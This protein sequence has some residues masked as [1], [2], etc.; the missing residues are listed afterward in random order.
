MR[1]FCG[2]TIDRNAVAAALVNERGGVIATSSVS[3][4]PVGY[5]ELCRMWVRHTDPATVAVADDG[6]LRTLNSLCSASG[7]L[8]ASVSAGT[9]TDPLDR[10]VDIAQQLAYGEITAQAVPDADDEVR[11]LASALHVLAAAGHAARGAVVELLRQCHPAALSAWDDPTEPAALEL[12]CAIPDPADAVRTD[13]TQLA[14]VLRERADPRRISEL[15]PALAR[16]AADYDRKQ[17]A[18][19]SAAVV[20]AAEAALTNERACDALT[21][22]L[23]QRLAETAATATAPPA[24]PKAPTRTSA[25]PDRT[26]ASTPPSR[27]SASE[28][29]TTDGWLESHTGA[30]PVVKPA[31]QA[32]PPDPATAPKAKPASK[33]APK[34][35][36]KATPKPKPEQTRKAAS[37][38]AQ[39]EPPAKSKRS[40]K[41]A[42]ASSPVPA[43]EGPSL[44][45][46]LPQ[47]PEPPEFVEP[48]TSDLRAPSGSGSPDL[49]S[50][51]A[52]ELP[53][54][55]EEADDDLLIFS[56][57]RSAWFKGPAA[58]EE[59]GEDWSTPADEG[60]R[61]AAALASS[62]TPAA[63]TTGSGLPR[64]VPQANLVPG[65]AILS[66]APT[67]PIERDATT[68]ASRTAGYFRG[69]SRAR[70]E[71]VRAGV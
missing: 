69:W 61:A 26:P 23:R 38:A 36:S 56:Q 25:P 18:S 43:P 40:G 20:A 60:W 32:A 1:I 37:K 65:S 67:G 71:T 52:A 42:S 49:L 62:D 55:L 53:R 28:L 58:V 51:P 9:I 14:E 64:R 57:A 35:A 39:P 15:A 70:R 44:A 48:V 7:Q 30:H 3:D 66:D 41:S 29:A 17:A 10:A 34:S 50:A 8:T 13:V 12:L 19:T 33:P 22:S 47:M 27:R 4:D 24:P 63:E 54:E 16:S 2:L 5:L 11:R 6:K 68:L 46:G 31:K 59:P 21:E 45:A